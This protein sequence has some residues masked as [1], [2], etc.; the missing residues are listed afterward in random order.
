MHLRTPII[1]WFRRVSFLMKNIIGGVLKCISPVNSV[2]HSNSSSILRLR[3]GTISKIVVGGALDATK[4]FC[5][6]HIQY[7]SKDINHCT[8]SNI[9]YSFHL[10]LQ[11]DSRENILKNL[12]QE[13]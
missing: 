8:Y 5:S 6:P 10:L 12:L 13:I 9:S 1:F 2:F 4:S 3:V 7:Y 11:D